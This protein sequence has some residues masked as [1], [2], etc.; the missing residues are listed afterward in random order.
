MSLD[1]NDTDRI[2]RGPSAST[3][4]APLV[5]VAR[6]Q[7]R[8]GA[9]SQL[10]AAQGALVAVVR[11]QPGCLQYDLFE[12]EAQPGRVVFFERW[13]DRAA[14][15]QHMRGAHMDAFRA[16]AGPLIGDFDLLQMRQ[17]A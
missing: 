11:Q 9:A 10:V 1:F 13:R 2:T 7:A 3:V 14:W 15:E 16:N 5:I 17:I 6:V 8:Q 4:H 12:D